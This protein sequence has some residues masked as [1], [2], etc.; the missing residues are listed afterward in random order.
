MREERVRAVAEA[1]A[2]VGLGRILEIEER[3]DPQYRF[4]SRVAAAWGGDACLLAVLNA[5]VSYRLAGRG[6]E[7]WEYW[8]QRFS[9]RRGE[10]CGEF[11]RFVVESPFLRPLREQRLRRVERVCRSPPSCDD[12]VRLVHALAVA[13]G[14]DWRSK[15]IVF[16]AKM[17]GY[18]LR[19]LGQRL[20][21]PMEIPI[22]VDYRV[23]RMT[24]CAGLIDVD[25]EAAMRRY[26]A[27]QDV[28]SRVAQLSG[29]PPL[30]IDTLVWLAGRVVIHGDA[31]YELPSRVVEELSHR[32][33]KFK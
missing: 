18:A 28:W 6:E 20:I 15:T 32:C 23:A 3:V 27:V 17:A 9:T 22:P 5:V 7:H 25:A 19:A 24:Y 4:V 12:L 29:V 2:E 33:R 21:F 8:S 14:S 13:L 16:A 26:R 31:R 1:I 11:A 10:P 30:H